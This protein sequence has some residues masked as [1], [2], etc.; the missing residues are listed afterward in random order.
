MS[1]RNSSARFHNQIRYNIAAQRKQKTDVLDATRWKLTLA[2]F[3]FAFQD[4]HCYWLMFNKARAR[5]PVFATSVIQLSRQAGTDT[6]VK[7]PITR[8]ETK[9][10]ETRETNEPGFAV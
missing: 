1:D 4:H 8:L 2:D 6:A 3:P 9:P 5:I 10:G 7:T